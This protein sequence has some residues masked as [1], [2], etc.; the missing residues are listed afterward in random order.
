[1]LGW[2]DRQHDTWHA[3]C[4]QEDDATL[5]HILEVSTPCETARLFSGHLQHPVNSPVYNLLI[6]YCIWKWQDVSVFVVCELRFYACYLTAVMCKV[7]TVN[8]CVRIFVNGKF[9]YLLAYC[10]LV[11][12]R[13]GKLLYTSFRPICEAPNFLWANY[14]A[15]LLTL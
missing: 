9:Y 4:K 10:V 13:L 12:C 11:N 14:F 6:V 1:M 7:L 2:R 8:Y 3:L 5:P 15:T